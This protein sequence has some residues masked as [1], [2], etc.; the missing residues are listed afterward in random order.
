MFLILIGLIT[1]LIFTSFILFNL[2][3]YIIN[4]GDLFFFDW[5]LQY[6]YSYFIS[7]YIKN[8]Q[9]FINTNQ[10]YPFPNNIVFYDP[11]FF[12]SIF[13]Y[14]PI[15]YI[16]KNNVI[17]LN[18]FIIISFFLNFLSSTYIINKLVKNRLASIFGGL[19]YTFSPLAYSRVFN[20]HIEY[21]QRYFIPFLIYYSIYFI[22][23]P[24]KKFSI[25]LGLIIFLSFITNIQLTVFSSVFIFIFFIYYFFFF[26]KKKYLKRWLINILKNSIFI[27]LFFIPL[28]LI[29]NYYFSFLLNE[30]ITRT[31]HESSYVKVNLIDFFLTKKLIFLNNLQSY[32]LIKYLFNIINSEIKNWYSEYFL[33]PGLTTIF[34]LI[35]GIFLKKNNFKLYKLYFLFFLSIILSF[36]PFIK[37]FNYTIKTPYYFLYYI[38]PLIRVTRTPSRILLVSV[39]FISIITAFVVKKL[40]KKPTKLK[41][42]FII[43]LL[44]LLIIEFKYENRFNRYNLKSNDLYLFNQNILDNKKIILYPFKNNQKDNIFFLMNSIK[45]NFI[46]VNG[47]HGSFTNYYSK[48]EKNIEELPLFNI[49]WF[50]YLQALDIDYFIINLNYKDLNNFNFKNKI[51]KK[52]K[53]NHAEKFVAFINENWLVVDIKKYKISNCYKKFKN[54]INKNNIETKLIKINNKNYIK[55]KIYNNTNCY[56]RSFYKNRYLNLYLSIYKNNKVVYKTKKTINIDP[57]IKP[58]SYF[59][60]YKEVEL[61]KNLSDL[62]NLNILI[63]NIN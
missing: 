48:L 6:N 1:T 15:F 47:Y 57:I 37:I 7:K 3:Y 63:K 61:P 14:S 44:L 60:Y 55:F 19:V 41:N 42:F 33:S 13:I 20:G 24:N 38:Y 25:I 8:F 51:I 17:S 22:K 46:M 36:G 21:I 18:I 31:I 62:K 16:A 45:H 11:I 59:Y 9:E 35:L 39:F 5:L 27:F 30:K 56:L 34:I 50:S 53:N 2:N 54:I 10:F 43:I 58:N 32:P 40:L 49:S 4:N 26:F 12:P 52:I 28:I 29:Y 23:N